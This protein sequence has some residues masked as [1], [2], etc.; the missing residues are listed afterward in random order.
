[1]L[2]GHGGN[3]YDAAREIG[4]DPGAILD[5]SS[6]VSPLPLK[7][8][9]LDFLVD[10]LPTIQ[11]LPEP[12]SQTL[13]ETLS[14]RTGLGPQN[15]LVGNGTTEWIF[16]IP[17]VLPGIGRVVIPIPT[18]SDYEDAARLAGKEPFFLGPFIDH[19]EGT[20]GN[21]DGL[22]K[23][24]EQHVRPGD[25]IFL[26]NPNNPTGAFIEP[27]L[28]H[29]FICNFKESLWVVDESYA[30][31]IGP[32]EE[33]SLLSKG[34][35]KNCLILRSF[36]KIYGIPGLRIGAISGPESLLKLLSERLK[37][38]SVGTLAQLSGSYLLRKG[39]WEAE[40]RLYLKGEKKFLKG[41]IEAIPGLRPLGS[42]THFFLVQV[43]KEDL[44]GKVL[45]KR[46]LKRKIL[47]RDCSNFR[48][49]EGADII[50]IS[51]RLREENEILIDALKEELTQ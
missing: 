23:E 3:I 17:A 47:V 40:T 33:S 16:N 18:Y 14:E 43:T 44:S 24:L 28:L 42:R 10:R 20:S 21:G 9:F 34:V 45:A 22:L 27:G 5:F 31:F 12:D 49:L 39:E 11:V 50:R 38:W 46:L 29:E 25:L 8:P 37:P 15:F 4:C 32:D 35:V 26:C 48:G 2:F 19:G 51:P 7:R 13:R 41:K 36:S 30:P 6:N 1:M